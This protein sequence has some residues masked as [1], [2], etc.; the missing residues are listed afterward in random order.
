MSWTQNRTH[1]EGPKIAL[2]GPVT[3]DGV[4]IT[5]SQR[6]LISAL[7]VHQNAGANADSVA[8][9]MWGNRVPISARA[10]VQN[11]VARLRNTFGP[12]LIH[13]QRDRY[14]LGG[15]TDIAQFEML[16]SPWLHQPLSKKA[17]PL[18]TA[19]LEL[20]RGI[21]FENV[22]EHVYAVVERT[23]LEHL[24][25][26]AIERLAI[27]RLLQGQFTL[28]IGELLVRTTA[29][30]FHERAWELLMIALYVSGRRTEAL[31][32]YADFEEQLST[33]LAAK[34]SLVLRRLREVIAL[35]EPLDV[36]E[37]L[38]LCEQTVSAPRS[39]QELAT[40]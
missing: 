4:S 32:S 27:A 40:A 29:A 6:A 16:L 7:A 14:R 34:P 35:D 39:L 5:K 17:I 33:E 3:I 10:S 26:L 20:W 15:T 11:Q 1:E 8:D 12:E 13:T 9:I 36:I 25:G 18:L 23:R 24:R 19:A 21:P 37:S 38:R 31:H 30:P 28:T 2:L 22:D